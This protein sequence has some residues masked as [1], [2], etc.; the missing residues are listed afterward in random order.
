MVAIPYGFDSGFPNVKDDPWTKLATINEHMEDGQPVPPDLAQWLG[1]AIRHSDGDANELMRRLGL[2]RGRGRVARK[3]DDD[4]WFEWGGRV[5][6]RE[7]GGEAPE[8]AISI[9]L[10]EHGEATGEEVSR[11]QLQSWRE[12]YR[13]ANIEARR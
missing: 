2:K 1:N 9:V 3:H 7:A 6:R 5:Y 12:T 8:A 13:T 10:R 4:A 11:S